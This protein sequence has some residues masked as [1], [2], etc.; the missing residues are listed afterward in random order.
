MPQSQLEFKGTINLLSD[1]KSRLD[2]LPVE[3]YKAFV[4]I[5]APISTKP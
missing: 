5:S 4:Q 3:Y 1:E 2:G